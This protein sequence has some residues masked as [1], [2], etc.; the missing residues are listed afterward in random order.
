MNVLI[1]NNAFRVAFLILA[2]VLVFVLGY[3]LL[4]STL[5][6]VAILPIVGAAWIMG[7]RGGVLV[8]LLMFPVLSILFQWRAGDGNIWRETIWLVGMAVV[9]VVS[10][11]VGQM[12]NLSTSL[13]KELGERKKTE[14]A[15]RQSEEFIRRITEA[16]TDIV[17][18]YD[19]A[20][21]R[22]VYTSR[23]LA[24][25]LGYAIDVKIGEEQAFL[26]QV[27]HPDDW[28]LM[29]LRPK[30]Y[31]LASDGEIMSQE[32]R[33]R[34][35][36]G[37][38]LW[39][40]NRET[41]FMRSRDG[42][43]QQIVGTSH[44]ITERKRTANILIETEKLQLALQ[45]ERELTQLKARFMTVISHEFRT[46]LAIIQSSGE[47]LDRYFDR[48]SQTR[49]QE[50]ISTI[51]TQIQ[52]V[53]DM[54]NDMSLVAA[55]EDHM[56][57]KP[58]PA[59]LDV[60]CK[61]LSEEIAQAKSHPVL[62]SASGDL[63]HIPVD[64]KLLH[65]ILNNLLSNAIKYSPN[66]E[67]VHLDVRQEGHS[68][69]FAVRDQGI[70]IPSEDQDRIFE[71]FYRAKNVGNVVGTGLGLRIARDYVELHGGTITMDSTPGEGSC[72]TVTLPVLA[73]AQTVA[74][75]MPIVTPSPA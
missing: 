31:R 70:G 54:L 59:D 44:D 73:M 2:Y 11:I 16:S 18:V 34:H 28:P 63:S 53:S 64:V 23:S 13:K 38:W 49:R 45:K 40:Y 35:A 65:H 26:K 50:C 15:L 68:V 39:F 57:Y 5:G 46:P 30:H 47:L 41:V 4:G 74:D 12:R 20:S 36:N 43:P 27:M 17:Y 71:T 21:S 29:L 24:T 69:S 55:G 3:P 75:N 72:F 42:S 52:Y 66:G 19:M 62:Y 67:P 10:I 14:A 22:F 25:V 1:R 37:D 56:E 61:R 9:L 8:W 7:I 32:Y 6:V 51:K 60:F 58:A 48:L 33:L